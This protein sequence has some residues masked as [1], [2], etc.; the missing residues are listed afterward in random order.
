[1]MNLS[2][3][4]TSTYNLT[5]TSASSYY[6]SSLEY[7]SGPFTY[8]STESGTSTYWISSL[9]DSRT[10]SSHTS[11]STSLTS[12]SASSTTT[13]GTDVQ[14]TATTI[15]SSEIY[16]GTTAYQDSYTE[17]WSRSMV[18]LEF[19]HTGITSIVSVSSYGNYTYRT[20]TYSNKTRIDTTVTS[21]IY[22]TEANTNRAIVTVSRTDTWT[23]SIGSYST[24]TD[25][26]CLI[27][28]GVA[29]S[30]IWKE[31]SWTVY[32]GSKYYSTKLSSFTSLEAERL[33]GTMYNSTVTRVYSD[34]KTTVTT[35]GA[36]TLAFTSLQINTFTT[37]AH[38]SSF[39]YLSSFSRT[40]TSATSSVTY[41][42]ATLFPQS[43]VYSVDFSTQSY[44]HEWISYTYESTIDSL[45]L[46]S[47]TLSIVSQLS[48][49][50]VESE[51]YSRSWVDSTDSWSQ[52]LSFGHTVAG[53]VYVS[54]S[55]LD[56]GYTFTVDTWTWVD[57]EYVHTITTKAG[58]I[59]YSTYAQEY[60]SVVWASSSTYS[61]ST[62]SSSTGSSSTWFSSTTY[63]GQFGVHS[64][65]TTLSNYT[66]IVSTAKSTRSQSS[67]VNES[68]WT[69]P[70]DRY[71]VIVSTGSSTYPL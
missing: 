38:G 34:E 41:M 67:L 21:T 44:I 22:K 1:M 60:T 9:Q 47:Q 15:E 30:L 51:T 50:C 39:T 63:T 20:T 29:S 3:Y 70:E 42:S 66:S 7:G 35:I 31:S 58:Y 53:I 69:S 65:E 19:T 71:S 62:F 18:S 27:S 55:R 23:Q 37:W 14:A 8:T 64:L 57:T 48:S 16:G 17:T 12:S 10:V 68:Q 11:S 40:T 59:G 43:Y 36:E 28:K 45:Y 6:T 2:A 25:I 26:E 56:Y 52:S 4:T 24:T 13:S 33:S 32:L 5:L 54:D 49:T 46:G 61:A